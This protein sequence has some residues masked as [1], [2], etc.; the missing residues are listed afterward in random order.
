[1]TTKI[2]KLTR[3][4]SLHDDVQNWRAGLLTTP[5]GVAFDG[6]IVVW[7]KRRA[8]YRQSRRWSLGWRP[9][10]IAQRLKVDFSEDPTM[11][12]KVVPAKAGNDRHEAIYQ[13]LYIQGRGALKRA[14]SRGK[15]FLSDALMISDRPAEIDDRAVRSNVPRGGG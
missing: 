6:P 2:S 15:S 11:R 7:K 1:M 4:S 3:N 10:Q 13:A 5:E 9:E 8:V 12:I 14:R